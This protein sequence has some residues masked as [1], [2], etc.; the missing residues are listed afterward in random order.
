MNEPPLFRQRA[1]V[2]QLQF[3]RRESLG[4]REHFLVCAAGE[5]TSVRDA[6]IFELTTGKPD[7]PDVFDPVK[8]DAARG[9]ELLSLVLNGRDMRLNDLVGQGH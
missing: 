2:T 8:C 6:G 7:T 1:Q 3:R 5:G 9:V 4:E